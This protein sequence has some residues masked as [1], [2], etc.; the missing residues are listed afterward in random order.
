VKL[1]VPARR[2]PEAVA[3]RKRSP[4]SCSSLP[5]GPTPRPG[6]VERV[7]AD[8]GRQGLPDR[9]GR[10]QPRRIELAA[11]LEGAGGE[12][13]LI[14][15]MDQ[16]PGAALVAT[17]R[18]VPRDLDHHL[19]GARGI[20]DIHDDIGDDAGTVGAGED[21]LDGARSLWRVLAESPA[22]GRRAE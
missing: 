7:G 3:R 2:A 18:P 6:Q 9:A 16:D 21:G 17:G 4:A 11:D 22:A 13:Q 20:A 15:G 19:G 8:P 10:P 1:V 5:R 14:E 12:R